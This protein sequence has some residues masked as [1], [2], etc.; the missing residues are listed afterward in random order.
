MELG[1]QEVRSNGSK[2]TGVLKWDGLLIVLAAG[3]IGELVLEF[4]AWWVV[5]ATLGRPMRPDILVADI[6]QSLLSVEISVVLAATI[7]LMLGVLI[8]PLLFVVARAVIQ[9]KTTMIPAVIYGVILWAIAQMILAPLAGRP[10]MLGLIPYTWAS[11]VGHV[12]YTVVF[13]YAFA[14]L[15]EHSVLK[16]EMPGVV[17]PR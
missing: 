9:F 5:P 4:F 10:F 3:G 1:D 12:L 14:R 2:Y 17:R 16:S 13:A 6:A 15:S 8:F 7:H 11:L